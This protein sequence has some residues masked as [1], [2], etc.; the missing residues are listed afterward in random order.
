MKAS[1]NHFLIGPIE[2]E[3]SSK[4]SDPNLENPQHFSIL[5]FVI[6][7]ELSCFFFRIANNW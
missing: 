7:N 6:L 2:P 1:E 4:E 3:I 5:Y